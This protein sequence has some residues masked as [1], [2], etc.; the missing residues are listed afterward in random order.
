MLDLGYEMN[1]KLRDV[2]YDNP[3][4]CSFVIELASPD[5]FKELAQVDGYK[6]FDEA[7]ENI[8]LHEL[9]QV[10]ESFHPGLKQFI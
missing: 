6:V 2:L 8:I 9:E 1:A 10:T 7:V 5:S 3:Y 4:A